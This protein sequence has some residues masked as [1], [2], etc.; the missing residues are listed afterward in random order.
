MDAE[1]L[2]AVVTDEVRDGVD[3]RRPKAV[4]LRP[5][6]PELV[7]DAL[8]VAI[9]EV[10]QETEQCSQTDGRRLN[11]TPYLTVLLQLCQYSSSNSR[12]SRTSPASRATA[13]VVA[14]QD[15]RPLHVRAQSV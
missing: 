13:P 1:L 15:D 6:A 3:Q 8:D 11:H 14:R 7:V 5:L 4:A 2:N 9:E 10:Q 12:R